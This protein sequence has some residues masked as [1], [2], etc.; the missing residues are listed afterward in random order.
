MKKPKIF[1]IGGAKG[2][3]KTSLTTAISLE[4]NLARL[5]TGRV[6]FEYFKDMPQINFKDY[7]TKKILNNKKDTILDTHFAQ[8]PPYG[9][10][11][12]PF[13]RGLD[14]EHILTLSNNFDIYPCLLELDPK[15]LLQRRLDDQ[16]RRVIIS[17]LIL[18]ELIFNQKAAD[19]YSL[20][21]KKPLFKLENKN[22]EE[23]KNKII[24]WIELYPEKK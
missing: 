2:V 21:L 5:E 15:T 23:T 20:E 6:L 3:G 19:L 17:K 10:E 13:E 18:E 14:S 1:M 12:V 8:Y 16:K 24:N 7:L 9:N 11:S 4:K 22:F